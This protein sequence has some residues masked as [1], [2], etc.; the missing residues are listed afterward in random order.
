MK[1]LAILGSTGSIG[2]QTLDV[3]RSFP[4]RFQV[5]GLAAGQNSSLLMEQVEEFKPRVISCAG[6]GPEL[7]SDLDGRVEW[8]S[9]EEIATHPDVEAVVVSTVGKVGIGP[10]LAAIRAGKAIVLAN[11]E[12][13]VA[14]GE[15]VMSEARRFNVPVLPVDSEPSAIWQCLQGEK[16]CLARIILTAS[17]GPFRDRPIDE[18]ADVT[19]EE[20]LNHPTWSMGK[21]IT[22]DSSTLMNK[23]MEVIES[24]WL[25]NVPFENIDVV[26]HPQSIVHSFVE[27]E[28]GSLKAQIGPTDMRLPIQYALTHPERWHNAQTPR[29]NSLAQESFTFRE[30]DLLRYPCFSLAVESGKKGGTYPAVMSAAD[31]VAVNLF[32]NRR[33]GFND[34]YNVVDSA[35]EK[36]TPVYNPSLD[37]I[38]E[39]DQW[40]RAKASGP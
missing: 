33:I 16:D 30:L 40:A 2:R 34:I 20:A 25:F 4:D 24:H 28:D 14:A 26:V 27:F 18:L 1:N 5:I 13:I 19:P 31:E 23:G 3:I 21:K 6:A 29:L 35:L 7:R 39:A 10:T 9:L 36:H 12:V 38:L 8:A 15:L 37:Q 32:L 17:G 22:I 11:K